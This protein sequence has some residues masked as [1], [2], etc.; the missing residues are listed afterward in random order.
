MRTY[1][2]QS[3][4]QPAPGFPWGQRSSNTGNP[5][6]GV[7]QN[8]VLTLLGTP[9]TGN[10]YAVNDGTNTFSYTVLAGN[11][12]SDC[13]TGLAAVIDASPSYVASAHGTEVWVTDGAGTSFVL[14]DASANPTIPGGSISIT[15][16]NPAVA[17]GNMDFSSPGVLRLTNVGQMALW[18]Q[19]LS[20]TSYQVTLWAYSPALGLFHSLSTTT[21]SAAT[22]VILLDVAA[23]DGVFVELKTFVGNAVALVYADGNRLTP[24]FQG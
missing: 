3:P 19:L 14:T 15:N 2:I 22:E 8:T 18:C 5:N 6:T 12:L 20:G 13:A 21:V 7:R 1:P 23:L 9:Q 11:T 17:A 4:S 10:T 16:V 24:G